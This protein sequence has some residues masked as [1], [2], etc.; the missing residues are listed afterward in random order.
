MLS[1]DLCTYVPEFNTYTIDICIYYAHLY[2][3]HVVINDCNEMSKRILQIYCCSKIK[4]KDYFAHFIMK[5][6]L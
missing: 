4:R 3:K 6:L 1:E 2:S 5:T